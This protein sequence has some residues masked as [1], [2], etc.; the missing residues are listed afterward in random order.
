M[1]GVYKTATGGYS[2]QITLRQLAGKKKKK[3]KLKLPSWLAQKKQSPDDKNQPRK[4]GWEEKGINEL[5]QIKP[6]SYCTLETG[7]HGGRRGRGRGSG[8]ARR[9]REGILKVSESERAAKPGALSHTPPPKHVDA[10]LLS[11]K[12]RDGETRDDSRLQ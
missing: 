12:R 9:G 2:G 4:G 11:Q 1:I 10:A 8:G 3:K 7:C 6:C 5:R